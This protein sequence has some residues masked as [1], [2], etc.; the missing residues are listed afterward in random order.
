MPAVLSLG[1]RPRCQYPADASLS[2][3]CGILP[4]APRLPSLEGNQ[5]ADIVIVGAGFAGL[6]AAK[7]LQDQD[8]GLR[9]VVLEAQGLAWA[10][11]GRN[12]GFV[13]DLPHE[14]N[15]D[16]YTGGAQQDLDQ[17]SDNRLAIE[18]MA[19][20]VDQFGLQPH[21]ARAG[22][23]HGATNGAGLKALHDFATHLDALNEPYNKLSKTELAELIGTEYYD[24]GIFTPGAVQIQPAGYIRGLGQA[25]NAAPNTTVYEHS[26]VVAIETQPEGAL[27]RT[28]E[29]SITAGRVILANNGHIESFGVAK[30]CLL[31]LFTY[32]SLTRE[33]STDELAQLGP[34]DSWGLIPASPMG[35]TLRKLDCGRM[36][37]RNQWTYNPDLR[38]S[39]Q[40]LARYAR[41][42]DHCFAR[43]YPALANVEM[44][45]RWSGAVTLS[46]NGSPVFGEVAEKIFAAAGCQGLGTTKS[47]LMG[48]LIADK[49]LGNSSDALM[50][51]EKL[52]PPS[53][54]PPRLLNAIGVPAYLKWVHWRAGK[55]L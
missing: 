29:G 27:V 5:Q 52:P 22:K 53:R 26:P 4:A 10:A 24:G 51:L 43:R 2:G 39:D 55:D 12:S 13:I 11:S 32:A 21:F 23:Y 1:R 3:W 33:L 40:Q 16:N 42:H 48:M 37:V 20:A 45:Y 19:A 49:L 9:V 6:A 44:E 36:L 15:S 54:M 31:H 35:T 30:G 28:E 46:L 18:F 25:L 47:T 8:P 38:S 41:Q 50:R 7:R 17:V 14:L 34:A